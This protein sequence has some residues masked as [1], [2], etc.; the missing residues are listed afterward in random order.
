[1]TYR[2]RI[3]CRIVG[4]LCHSLTMEVSSNRR[5]LPSTARARRPLTG[6]TETKYG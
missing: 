4:C 2:R 5:C 6:E 1:M 3:S